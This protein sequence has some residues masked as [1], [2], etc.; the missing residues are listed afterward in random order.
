M[1]SLCV[2]AYLRCLY[3]AIEYA[4]DLELRN[5]AIKILKDDFTFSTIT[6][7][8]DTTGWLECN[9]GA[10]YLRIM[11][12]I[13]KM[14]YQNAQESIENLPQY[15]MVAIVAQKILNL[16]KMKITSEKYSST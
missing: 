1:R 11:R 15:E 7:L 10:K 16:L 14:P 8:C 6:Q 12:H 13:L 4:P 2:A 5:E 9:I 3:A